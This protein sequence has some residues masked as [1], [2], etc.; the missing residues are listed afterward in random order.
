MEGAGQLTHGGASMGNII[1]QHSSRGELV[2]HP[3]QMNQQSTA[4]LCIAHLA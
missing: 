1:R 2:L 4:E 3:Q